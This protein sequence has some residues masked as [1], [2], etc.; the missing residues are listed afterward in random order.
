M[1][2]ILELVPP[3]SLQNLIYHH[4]LRHDLLT[5]FSRTSLVVVIENAFLW[6]RSRKLGIWNLAS[7]SNL[8]NVL[9]L[10]LN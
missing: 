10:L 4:T 1:L 6:H 9:L 7:K 8:L 2:L 5:D 3:A